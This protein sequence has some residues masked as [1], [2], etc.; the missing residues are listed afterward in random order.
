MAATQGHTQS[1]HTNALDEALALPTDFSA[2][3]ARNTQLLLQQESGTTRVIDPWGGSY[4]VE[5]LTYDLA[6]RAWAHIEE[7]EEAGGMA[8]GHRRG[9]PEAAHRGGRGPHPGADRLRAPAGDR[10]QQVPAS[11]ADEEIDV[12]KVDNAGVRAQQ[13]DK[14]RR[15]REERDERAVDAALTALTNAAAA[16]RRGLAARRTTTTCWRW[17]STRPAR[18]PPSGRSPTRW[19]RCSGGTP[20]RSVPSPVCTATRRAPAPAVDRA[21]EAGR[22]VR[23]G[24]GA[25]AAH[26]GRQDGPGRPRPRPEGDRHRVRRPRLRRRRRPAVPDPGRGGP[27]GGRGRRAR[28]RRVARWP[29]GTS[30]W[31]RSC[32]TSWPRSAGPTSWSSSAG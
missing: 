8:A 15:L 12:L 5:R 26:P 6:R 31:C 2:R 19:R 27:P 24:G 13:I 3:I 20:G 23:R 9:H 4:Y 28:R 29:P 25:P 22:R 10:R 11:T 21:R 17:R 32:A 7:V 30:R 18:R 16:E 14:L 1:L